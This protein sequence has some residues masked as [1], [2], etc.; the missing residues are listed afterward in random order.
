MDARANARAES[1]FDGKCNGKCDDNCDGWMNLE[2]G[3]WEQ[4]EIL[5]AIYPATPHGVEKIKK[6]RAKDSDA[7][8][9]R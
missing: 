4:F 9:T 3:I 5:S 6:F 2:F 8:C 7:F 1:N